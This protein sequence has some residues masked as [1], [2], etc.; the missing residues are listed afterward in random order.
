MTPIQDG[1]MPSAP[2]VSRLRDTLLR[3]QHAAGDDFSGIGLIIHQDDA[4]LPIFPLRLGV[5]A[6]EA[7]CVEAALAAIA[8]THS[9]LHDGFHLLS[10]NWRITAI[11][12]Y[13]SPQILPNI[14]IDRSKSFGGRYVAAL[15]GSALPGV[16]LCGIASNHFGLAIFE[17]GREVLFEKL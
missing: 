5:E 3:I 9:D 8:S 13:F 12:Q 15:F 11:A 16:I 1:T 10:T 4:V 6:P 17:S 2:L 7:T 14:K